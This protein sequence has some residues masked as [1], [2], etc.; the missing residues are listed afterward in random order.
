M[1]TY[2]AT[3]GSDQCREAKLQSI[4]KDS[5]VCKIR[6]VLH[7]SNDLNNFW[8]HLLRCFEQILPTPDV[9]SDVSKYAT[10]QR[11]LQMRVRRRIDQPEGDVLQYR[12]IQQGWFLLNETDETS[13]IPDINVFEIFTI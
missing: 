12:S 5:N 11:F 7:Q 10:Q 6:S 2:Q 13:Q 1:L 9:F 8:S 4:D 3:T